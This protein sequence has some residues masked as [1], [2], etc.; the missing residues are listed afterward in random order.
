MAD[1]VLFFPVGPE[2]TLR[3]QHAIN[4]NRDI[5]EAELGPFTEQVLPSGRVLIT[6]SPDVELPHVCYMS[7]KTPEARLIF[8]DYVPELGNET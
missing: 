4:S 6:P 3:I 1:E 2:E 5:I 8:D 7:D